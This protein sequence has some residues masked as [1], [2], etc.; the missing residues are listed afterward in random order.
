VSVSALVLT[1]V[2]A[3][4][5]ACQEGDSKPV[6]LES[7]AARFVDGLVAGKY[8]E[9]QADFDET[10]K[11]HAS[12]DKL[13]IIWASLKKRLGSFKARTGIRTEKHKQYDFVFVTCRF[14]ISAIDIKVVFD[15][16]ERIT[17]FFFTPIQHPYKT[18]SYVNTDAF[19]EQE[20]EF[21]EPE[22]RL[23]GTLTLPKTGGPFPSVVL[24]HGSG[25][26]DRDETIGPNRPFKDLAWGL[27]TRGIAVLRYEKRTKAHGRKMGPMEDLTL[28]E[29]TVDDA[30]L[31]VHLLRDRKA[32]DAKSV[33]VLG[34]SLGGMAI[35]RIGKRG[36]E[37]AGFIVLAGPTRPFEDLIV[38]QY[39]YIFSL[40]DIISATEKSELAELKEKV[41]RVKDPGLSRKTPRTDLPLGMTAPY[42]LDLRGY[43]PPAMAKDLARPMLIL[44]GERDYQ[45]TMKDFDGW[46]KALSDRKDVTFK[47]YPTLNHLFI[48]GKGPCTPMEY[49]KV[50][51][52]D[53]SVIDTVADWIK[54]VAQK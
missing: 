48:S 21:G 28:R 6:D 29:E 26:N 54:G 14:E 18:P 5:P 34:H 32:L 4:C 52:V 7:R 51:H 19:T 39:E 33:F 16:K 10:M 35:P 20:V 12:P 53:Q 40:D 36:E 23:P 25:P 8:V 17:G 27:A 47:S 41:A 46:K 37:I 43:H 42:W 45:V 30:L 24:V 44:Q 38:A 50:G 22:W 11:K 49:Q 9:V 13:K 3:A 15:R 2:L 31:A 1:L